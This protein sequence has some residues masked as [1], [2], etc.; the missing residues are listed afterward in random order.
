MFKRLLPILPVQNIEA[1]IAFYAAMGFTAQKTVS[2]FIAVQCNQ[3]L[4]GL[5]KS[6]EM[7]P[8]GDLHWQMEVD[9]IQAAYRRAAEQG[10]E[11]ITLPQPHPAGF[12]M[13]Q[14]ATP[15]GYTLTLEGPENGRHVP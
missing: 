4:F 1:E 11:I 3:V 2:G 12:W 5:Q 9:N 7:V 6:A 15:N 10:L 8:P 13:L 14:L